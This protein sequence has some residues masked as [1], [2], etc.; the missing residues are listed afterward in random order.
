M[1]EHDQETVGQLLSESPEFRSLYN[2]H[3]L[4]KQQVKDAEDGA[5]VV[6]H[7]HLGEMKREK[8]HTK[9]KMAAIMA[10]H[11]REPKTQSSTA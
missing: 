2:R 6:D 11:Q 1:F 4:L 7:N 3:S 9:D 8:L 5:I 10:K